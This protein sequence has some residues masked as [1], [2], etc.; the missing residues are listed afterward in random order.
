MKRFHY[1]EKTILLTSFLI[2]RWELSYNSTSRLG[3]IVFFM[4]ASKYIDEDL[5]VE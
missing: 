2:P 5:K 3:A 4:K 1:F